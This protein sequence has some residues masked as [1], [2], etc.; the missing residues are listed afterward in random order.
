M[1]VPEAFT[2]GIKRLGREADRSPPSNAE[3]KKT[4]SCTTTPPYV[5]AWCIVIPTNGEFV[6]NRQEASRNILR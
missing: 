5:M 1:W 2:P 4:W 3:V 6:G